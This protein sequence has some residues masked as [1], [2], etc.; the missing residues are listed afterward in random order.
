MELV[1]SCD[2]PNKMSSFRSN[3]RLPCMITLLNYLFD[4]GGLKLKRAVV[5]KFVEFES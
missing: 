5:A 3:F 2:T 4:L 1:V